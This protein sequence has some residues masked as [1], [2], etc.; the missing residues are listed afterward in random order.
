MAGSRCQLFMPHLQ[1]RFRLRLTTLWRSPAVGGEC[2]WWGFGLDE[3]CGKGDWRNVCVRF[4][5]LATFLSATTAGWAGGRG[6]S[7]CWLRVPGAL[8][9]VVF[10]LFLSV[11]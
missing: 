4:A 11:G 2:A 6:S 1:T 3:M 5:W 9:S 7:V 10:V 8:C